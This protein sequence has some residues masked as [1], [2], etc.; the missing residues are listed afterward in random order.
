MTRL[1]WFITCDLNGV[2][3]EPELHYWDEEL[4]QWIPVR[5]LECKTWEYEEELER[6]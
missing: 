3:T 2:K 6:S 4:W 1:K 5:T